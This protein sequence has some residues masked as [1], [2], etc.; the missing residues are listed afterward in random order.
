MEATTHEPCLAYR[1]TVAG[2]RRHVL[3]VLRRAAAEGMTL[4]RD[5]AYVQTLIDI[6]RGRRVA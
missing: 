3:P 6:R 5:A 1:G 4:R 2:F